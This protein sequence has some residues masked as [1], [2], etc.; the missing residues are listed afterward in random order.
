MRE[1]L[2]KAN[3]PRCVTIIVLDKAGMPTRLH[4]SDGT[5]ETPAP[6]TTLE[7]LEPLR[8]PTYPANVV[9]DIDLDVVCGL[10]PGITAPVRSAAGGLEL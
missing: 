7:D 5:D 9:V 6:G 3:P 4:F 2:R 1:V 8:D 10:K